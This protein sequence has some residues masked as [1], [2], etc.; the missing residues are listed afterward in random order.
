[1]KLDN[2]VDLDHFKKMLKNL[3][4]LLSFEVRFDLLSN[5]EAQRKF[6]FCLP[7]TSLKSLKT[8][9]IEMR[10]ADDSVNKLADNLYKLISLE[11]LLILEQSLMDVKA[12][13]MK[14]FAQDCRSKKVQ[15]DTY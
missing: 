10:L 3:P 11:S 8:L 9:K 4:N 13:A 1:M 15:R 6:I 12:K 5:Y 14:K 2:S 7:F